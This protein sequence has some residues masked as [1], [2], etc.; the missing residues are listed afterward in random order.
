MATPQSVVA[1][2]HNQNSYEEGAAA[3][4]PLNPAVGCVVYETG[5]EKHVRAATADEKTKRV[6]REQRNPPRDVGAEGES[7][8]EVGY[9]ADDHVETVGFHSYDQA[10]VRVAADGTTGDPLA[11]EGDAVGWNADGELTNAAA[12]PVGIVREVVDPTAFDFH[13]AIVEFY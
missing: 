4:G 8:L 6:V 7:P 12:E 11:A 2:L 3:D 9:N 5:G 1:K 10:R 13:V